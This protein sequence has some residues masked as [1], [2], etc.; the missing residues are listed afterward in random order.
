MVGSLREGS[1]THILSTSNSPKK[2]IIPV[3]AVDHQIS[4]WDHIAERRG[5]CQ[6]LSL[7]SVTLSSGAKLKCGGIRLSGALRRHEVSCKVLD[8]MCQR[9]SLIVLLER[10]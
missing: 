5:S 8:H 10:S 4:H 1:T 6:L 2:S 7:P 3:Y 9:D